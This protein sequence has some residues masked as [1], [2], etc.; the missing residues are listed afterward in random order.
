MNMQ[1]KP[2][3]V[4]NQRYLIACGAFAAILI[5]GACTHQPGMQSSGK[6]TKAPIPT[7]RIAPVYPPQSQA[8][9]IEGDVLTCFTVTTEGRARNIHVAGTKFWTTNGM[10]PER[11][12]KHLLELEATALIWHW[13]FKP[14]LVNGKP[15]DTP[16]V[17]Q[18]ITFR[19]A[20]NSKNKT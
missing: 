11:N 19:I 8:E 20:Q 6:T 10:Q 2:V 5:L 4:V 1:T 17:C 7:L 12:G 13:R 18:T 15:V 16:N 9:G 3:T 14:R